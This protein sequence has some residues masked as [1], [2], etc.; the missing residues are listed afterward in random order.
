MANVVSDLL[1]A[2]LWHIGTFIVA[3]PRHGT[4]EADALYQGLESW[5]KENGAEWLR[6]GRGAWKCSRRAL[7]GTA[8][9]SYKRRLRHGVIMGKL[10]NT[11]RVMFKP[12][13]EA[14]LSGICSL[15]E[16]DV[17]TPGIGLAGAR[18][19]ASTARPL[20]VRPFGARHAC[21]P[22]AGA[23][24]DRYLAPQR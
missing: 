23:G 15:V 2:S 24:W 21:P 1:A 8:S 5:A 17:Q 12:L 18:S 6:L 3:T 9:A 22:R 4:G 10:T 13:V 11:L 14:P 20:W 7:L 16:R 19:Q